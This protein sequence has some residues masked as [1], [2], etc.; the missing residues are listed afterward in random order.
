[1]VYS[2]RRFVLYLA[3]FILFVCFSVILVLRLSRLGKRELST[4]RAFNPFALV[5]FCLFTLSLRVWEGL[6]LVTVALPGLSLT[7]FLH[8]YTLFFLFLLDCGVR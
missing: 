3:L 8:V 1:M 2:T 6:W 7:L 4:F 5:W